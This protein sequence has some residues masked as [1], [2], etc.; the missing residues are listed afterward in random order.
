MPKGENDGRARVKSPAQ[1][2]DRRKRSGADALNHHDRRNLWEAFR[3][4]IRIGFPPTCTIDFHPVHMDTYPEGELATWFKDELRNRITTWLRRRKVGWY[5]IWIRE[6]YAGDRREHLHLMIHCPARLRA[7]L[8]AAIEK[9]YPGNAEM[10]AMGALTWRKHPSSGRI[11][12]PGFEYRLKQMT[13][14]AQG[15]PRIG[16]PRREVKNRYDGSAVASVNGLRSGVSRTLDA[17]ARQRWEGEQETLIP[18]PE[19]TEG[20]ATDPA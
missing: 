15:P 19:T 1:R 14:R 2:P 6:N 7:E 12:C 17:K 8:K 9:W 16:R 4:G 10:V 5:A 13:A 18:S 20:G 3:H 11:A